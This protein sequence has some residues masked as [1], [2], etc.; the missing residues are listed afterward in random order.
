MFFNIRNILLKLFE[1]KSLGLKS[2]HNTLH[3]I[4]KM[5]F[6]SK[7]KLF[8]EEISNIL[9]IYMCILIVY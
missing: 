3:N 9:S 7:N 5:R 2:E 8:F 4:I 6:L 1:H